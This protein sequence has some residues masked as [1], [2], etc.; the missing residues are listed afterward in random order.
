MATAPNSS[1]RIEREL[2]GAEVDPAS[3]G[4]GDGDPAPATA[5][6]RAVFY[7]GSCLRRRTLEGAFSTTS[8]SST[9][10]AADTG[11]GGWRWLEPL[12]RFNVSGSTSRRAGF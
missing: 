12:F 5:E 9:P 3:G 10:I 7:Y 2:A 1:A 8:C 6:W 4:A 11:A